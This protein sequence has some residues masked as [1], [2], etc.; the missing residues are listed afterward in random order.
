MAKGTNKGGARRHDSKTI[1]TTT[2]IVCGNEVTYRKSRQHQRGGRYC[3]THGDDVSVLQVI[4]Y[5]KRKQNV[6]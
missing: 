5:R 4:S 1:R 3:K 2:C 6:A